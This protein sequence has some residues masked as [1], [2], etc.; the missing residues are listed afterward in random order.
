M[1]YVNTIR[2]ILSLLPLV[3]EVIRAVEAAFP[4]GG[5]GA[6]KLA[7]VREAIEGGY[8]LANDTVVAFDTVWPAINRIVDASVVAYNASGAFRK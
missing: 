8:N 6:V 4:Q 2:L 3:L 5:N 1:Q 7:L